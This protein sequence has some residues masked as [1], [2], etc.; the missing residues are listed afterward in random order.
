MLVTLCFLFSSL[1]LASPGDRPYG[2][3]NWDDRNRP[4]P[5]YPPPIHP[6]TGVPYPGQQPPPGNYDPRVLSVPEN[7]LGPQDIAREVLHD[8]KHVRKKVRNQAK[9][10]SKEAF[11]KATEK[12]KTEKKI[13][14]AAEKAAQKV[15]DKELKRI[16]EEKK[17][18]KKKKQQEKAFQKKLDEATPSVR[19]KRSQTHEVAKRNES[20]LKEPQVKSHFHIEKKKVIGELRLEIGQTA[21][22]ADSALDQQ[23]AQAQFIVDYAAAKM[24]AIGDFLTGV[25][26]GVYQG[27][28]TTAEALAVIAQ[29]PQFLDRVSTSIMDTLTDP[30]Q[31]IHHAKDSFKEYYRVLAYGSEFE[32]GEAVGTLASSIV[33]SMTGTPHLAQELAARGALKG[34]GKKLVAHVLETPSLAGI[35]VHQ[36]ATFSTLRDCVSYLKAGEKIDKL[37]RRNI[38]KAFTAETRMTRFPSDTTAYRYYTPGKSHARGH[39][40]TLEPVAHPQKDLALP[41]AGPYELTTWTIPSGTEAIDGLVAPEFGQAGGARQIFIRDKE[42]LR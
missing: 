31:F 1:A 32:Q 35:S 34:L 29:N 11:D 21:Q 18:E 13:E 3:I 33:M 30:S 5:Q 22:L 24:A 17:A 9:K 40:L 23:G 36:G 6:D 38:L 4:A 2:E 28:Y 19:E 20:L 39:W 16:K 15:V 8:S 41:H 27:F 42:V 7:K 26:S 10:A 37:E 14:K 25:H 12:G